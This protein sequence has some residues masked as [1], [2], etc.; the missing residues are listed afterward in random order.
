MREAGRKAAERLFEAVQPFAHAIIDDHRAQ[1]RRLVLATTTPDDMIRPLADRLGFD[2]V[3]ATRYGLDGDGRYDGSIDGEF[4]WGQGQAQGGAGTGPRR[5][6]STLADSWAYSDS[7]Y[8]QP[9]LGAV[10]HPV[11]VNPDPR[12]L[13]LA[14]VRRWPVRAPRRAPGRAQAA[15]PGDRAPAA[16]ADRWPGPS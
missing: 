13:A 4:V 14:T 2:D 16:A 8:D 12:M 6:A 5:T 10:G 11:V 9:L 3:V 7:Y 1:G 15:D